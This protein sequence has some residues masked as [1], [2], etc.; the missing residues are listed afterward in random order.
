MLFNSFLKSCL[1]GKPYVKQLNQCNISTINVEKAR[2][3]RQEREKLIKRRETNLRQVRLSYNAGDQS[4]ILGGEHDEIQRILSDLHNIS[5]LQE[6]PSMNFD[7]IGNAVSCLGPNARRS[8]LPVPILNSPSRNNNQHWSWT[9]GMICNNQSPIPMPRPT[10]PC[11]EKNTMSNVIT[12][13]SS[14]V[15]G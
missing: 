11:G 5:Q 1:H 15:Q 2:A 7:N 12:N 14:P 10:R 4:F 13:M 8:T 3:L 6:Q 9:D